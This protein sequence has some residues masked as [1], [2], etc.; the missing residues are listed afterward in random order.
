MFPK[1]NDPELIRQ[2]EHLDNQNSPSRAEIRCS[3]CNRN[4]QQTT[5]IWSQNPIK[6]KNKTSQNPKTNQQASFFPQKHEHK[7]P[8]YQIIYNLQNPE[9]L[10]KKPKPIFLQQPNQNLKTSPKTSKFCSKSSWFSTS[11][12][13][14]TNTTKKTHQKKPALITKRVHI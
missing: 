12:H 7:T 5:I 1:P 6:L 10:N 2:V 3:T 11:S 9:W 8:K 14:N 13:Q 4:P